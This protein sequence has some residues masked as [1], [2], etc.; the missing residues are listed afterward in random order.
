MSRLDELSARA[1]R[2]QRELDAEVGEAR[3]VLTRGKE[4]QS[5]VEI[6][7]DEINDLE[8]VTILLNSI[9]EERQLK[10]Q[11]LIENLVTRG[12][13]TIFDD[14]LSFHIVQSV[15][16]KT[17]VVDFV[18]RSTMPEATFETPVMEARGGGLAATIGFLLRVTVML[19]GHDPK[20]DNILVLDETFAHVSAEYI[21]ALG[22]F[23][24]ELREKT[25]IQIIMVT[26]QEEFLDY[27]DRVYRFSYD[28]GKTKVVQLA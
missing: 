23:L 24:H 4:L 27:A 10:A 9:G 28:N 8:R 1:A 25:G 3:A 17:A 7:G 13:Q 5:V 21:P 16:G 19:L 18:V 22:A 14:S 2:V 20:K 6:L 11:T 26:H 15:K 12:L